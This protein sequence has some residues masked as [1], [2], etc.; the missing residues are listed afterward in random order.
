MSSDADHPPG[1]DVVVGIVAG[2]A[3]ATL[4]PLERYIEGPASAPHELETNREM[5]GR[6]IVAARLEDRDS[7]DGVPAP[8]PAHLVTGPSSLPSVFAPAVR[9]DAPDH[10]V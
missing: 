3:L 10:S 5:G 4:R 8:E 1:L 7:H 2:V 6:D 9:R